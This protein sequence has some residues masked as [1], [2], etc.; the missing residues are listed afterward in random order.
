MAIVNGYVTRAEV[1]NALGLGTATIVPDSDEI[2]Q[3]VTAVS[4]AV[5]DYCGRF[6]Y[7]VAGTVV[8]TANDYMF[9]PIGD[10]VSVTTIKT[11]EDNSGT[12]H[13]TLTPNMDYRLQQNTTFPG[14]PFT[15]I[16]ITSFGSNTLP[17]GVTQG[18]EVVGT[19]GWS[20]VPEPIRAAA[21]IQSVRVHARRAT[22]FGVAG[23]PEGGI[24]RLLSRLDPDVELMV[25]PYRAPREAI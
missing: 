2:D 1:Q 24:V 9:L 3:V 11:D 21:L 23:S 6:F 20:A 22:P 14:W 17:V 5:D 10:W 18:V 16:Q 13:K 12:V 25:R 19:R 4:R 8:F 15:A 7:S